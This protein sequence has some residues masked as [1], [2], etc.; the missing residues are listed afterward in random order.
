MMFDYWFTD[1]VSISS[2]G[3][4]LSVEGAIVWLYLDPNP[5]YLWYK[6]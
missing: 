1:L 3:N 5:N 2:G 4:G 6:L